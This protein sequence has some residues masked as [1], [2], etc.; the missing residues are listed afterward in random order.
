MYNILVC[1][2]DKEIVEAIEDVYKRQDMQQELNELE[3]VAPI[4]LVVDDVTMEVLGKLMEQNNERIG[5]FSTEGGIFNILA[6]RYSDKTIIDLIL[7]AYT[8][9]RYAQDR[10]TRRGQALDHPL[11]TM[12]LYVQPIVIKEMR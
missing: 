1:D 2:D 3:E 10:M 8:G 5:I 6:G 7:K 11:I 9:D 4:R 12:L